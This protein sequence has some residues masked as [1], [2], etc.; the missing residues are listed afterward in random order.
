M[1]NWD[2]GDLYQ[3]F[4]HLDENTMAA[5]PL[6]ALQFMAA[7]AVSKLKMGKSLD[8]LA[9]FLWADEMTSLLLGPEHAPDGLHRW[10]ASGWNSYF[11]FSHLRFSQLRLNGGKGENPSCLPDNGVAFLKHA[12]TMIEGGDSVPL[13]AAASF[14]ASLDGGVCSPHELPLAEGRPCCVARALGLLTLADA[15]AVRG[16]GKEWHEIFMDASHALRAGLVIAGRPGGSPGALS[17]LVRSHWPF[18]DAMD[19]LFQSPEIILGVSDTINKFMRRELKS[20][21]QDNHDQK[22]YK[23]RLFPHREIVSDMV[24]FSKS[25]FCG[26]RPFLRLVERV[27]AGAGDQPCLG[28]RKCSLDFVE[29]GP[30]IG[31]CTL[32]AAAALEVAGLSPFGVGYEPL[33]DASALFRESVLANRWDGRVVVVPQ[34]LA[35]KDGDFVT[36]AF[37]PGHNGEG[38]TVRAATT[39]HCGNNCAGFKRIATV[40]LDSTWPALRPAAL[41]ILKLSVNGEELNALRGARALLSRRKVCSVMVHVTKV[42]RGYTDSKPAPQPEAVGGSTASSAFDTSFSS[43]FWELLNGVGGMEVSLHLDAIDGATSTDPPRPSTRLLTSASELDNV[44]GKPSTSQDYI[45]A[46]QVDVAKD[47]ACSG[48]R[49][50]EHWN[51]VFE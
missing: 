35:A 32:F 7:S 43:E 36:L 22:T 6:G 12:T 29:G 10:V 27:A 16:G 15:A 48:S 50:L 14:L 44:F 26:M 18:L 11:M 8:Q 28:G 1:L 39:A 3:K 13:Q 17:T 5:C 45:V 21:S 30:H 9:S 20:S 47:S 42:Q 34:A 4:I 49:A 2:I 40:S 46:R 19:K 51:E 24:R 37:Y 41:D 23:M 31:D 38:T 33:P 25:P